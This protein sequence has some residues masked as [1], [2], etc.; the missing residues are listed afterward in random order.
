MFAEAR[1][2]DLV[3]APGLQPDETNRYN[4][5]PSP[6]LYLS[7]E[8]LKSG[9]SGQFYR[10]YPYVVE[11]ATDDKPFFFHFF[12]W[13]QTAQIVAT[14]GRTWQPFGGSGYLILFVLLALVTALS[15][16]L[17]LAPL[18][19]LR[20]NPASAWSGVNPARILLYFGLLGAAFLFVEIPL[21][22]RWMLVTGHATYA[23]AGVVAI[24][25]V[26]SGFGSLLARR[27]TLPRRP[28]LFAL[29]SVAAVLALLGGR[30]SHA[31]LAWPALLQWV[32]LIL[33]LAPLAILMGL[34]FPWGL[35]YLEQRAPRLTALAWAVNG[36]A[37]VIASV[38]AAIL[39]IGAGFTAVILLGAAAYAFAAVLLPAAGRAAPARLA[40]R[41]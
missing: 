25:L 5:M 13:G 37:S 27:I 10:D 19:L 31:A 8:K 38:A 2:Y 6:D 34:P 17:I 39:T 26:G 36:C 41:A 1:R 12:R 9:E 40:S 15:A 3:A 24:L 30:V 35:A 18:L 14:L 7:L 33:M 16:A 29:A 20:R 4:Q 32:A 23:F 28:V 11:P 21:I 22:Q